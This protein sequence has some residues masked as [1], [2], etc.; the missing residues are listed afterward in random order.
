VGANRVII[1]DPDWNPS[2]DMQ[3]RE[4]AWRIG[5]KRD[6]TIY[7]FITSGTIEEKV[8]HRQ[9]YKHFLTNKILRD[10]RQRRFF[11]AKDLTDLFVLGD[12]D[13]GKGTETS[14]IFGGEERVQNSRGPN[15]RAR[16][17]N[18]MRK[19]RASG[20]VSAEDQHGVEAL[21]GPSRKGKEKVIDDEEG[22]EGLY[23]EEASE[24]K[25]KASGEETGLLKSLFESTGVHSTM[26][27]DKIVGAND[28][29]NVI[30]DYEANRVAKRAAEALRQSRVARAHADVAVPTWTGRSG[31][32][33]APE[34]VRRRFGTTV[35]PRIMQQ[36]RRETPPRSSTPP[37]SSRGRFGKPGGLGVSRGLGGYGA[38]PG[39]LSSTALLAKMREGRLAAEGAG[40]VGT[41]A[42][43]SPGG[44][45]SGLRSGRGSS[46]ESSP[47]VQ[48]RVLAI[49][50]RTS[51]SGLDEEGEASPSGRE[52]GAGG[53]MVNGK[54]TGVKAGGSRKQAGASS[55]PEVLIRHICTFLQEKGGNA[56]SAE[57]VQHFSDR[58][59]ARDMALFRQLLKQI[60]NLIKSEDGG[61]STWSIKN[62]Y[63]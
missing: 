37:E 13:S 7:R 56:P 44:L 35:N 48:R 11:K 30:V 45:G 18:E 9:I 6:V 60:A 33:G 15:V 16:L 41:T 8:Y 14:E 27:H 1:Y 36:Q 22:L 52:G 62:E 31:A 46:R 23:R 63:R 58:I 10:P 32:A 5:Q 3:A 28:P 61:P 24:E 26:D 20:G 4:R 54:Q 57:L 42:I 47:L 34:G 25:P 38:G 50:E 43:V 39:A 53:G 29:E 55:Q 59:D 12:G 21:E 17:L 19:A 51:P 49:G 2:T 40:D